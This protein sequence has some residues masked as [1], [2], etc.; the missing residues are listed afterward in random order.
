[1]KKK[2]RRRMKSG[3]VEKNEEEYGINPRKME[4]SCEKSKV[5]LEH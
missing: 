1:M 2:G 3:K 5:H 4:R